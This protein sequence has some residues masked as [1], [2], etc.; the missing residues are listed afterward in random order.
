MKLNIISWAIDEEILTK[1]KS[2]YA[3]NQVEN[4]NEYVIFM[5]KVKGCSITIYHSLQAVFQGKNAQSEA[6]IFGYDPTVKWLYSS[7]HAGSDEVGTGDYFGPIVVVASY[8]KEENLEELNRLG[9]RDSKK[10]SDDFILTV[11]PKLIRKYPYSLMVLDNEKYNSL[12][13]KGWNMNSLK[14]ALHN[15]ALHL[16]RKK[17]KDEEIPYFVVDQF[18][19]AK[20]YYKYLE[21]QKNIVNDIKF[22]TKGESKS[23]AVAL[24]SILARYVFLKK[25]EELAAYT[26]YVLPLGAN[27]KVNQI[28]DRIVKE[29][30]EAF[31]GKIAKINFKNT[32]KYQESLQETLF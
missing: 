15:Q 7:D 25:M 20:N 3:D 24:A 14:A 18:T 17:V 27:E 31:L 28:I 22:T 19:P 9:I 12:I 16:L 4:P 10:L 11:G 1:I 5:A 23:P 30:G 32:K 13:K 29:K 26:G 21:G 2:F 6:E 8:V